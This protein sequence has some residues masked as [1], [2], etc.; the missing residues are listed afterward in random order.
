MTEISKKELEELK[1]GIGHENEGEHRK[2]DMKVVK[3]E[4]QF[5]VSI[6]KRFAEIL[7]LD[8]KRDYFEFNLIPN[9]SKKEKFDLKAELK[10]G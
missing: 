9:N 10:K 8:E 7:E 1:R 5:R 2:K 6:P 4:K 3:D